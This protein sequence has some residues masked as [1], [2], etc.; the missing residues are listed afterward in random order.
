LKTESSAETPERVPTDIFA[1][2]NH[3]TPETIIKRRSETGSYF[4]VQARK[5]ANNRLDWPNV[6]VVK[7]AQ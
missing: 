5:L 4:G 2:T 3:V 7:K 1:A 6:A